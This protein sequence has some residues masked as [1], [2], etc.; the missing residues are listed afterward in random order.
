MTPPAPPARSSSTVPHRGL[1]CQVAE[2][3]AAQKYHHH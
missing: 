1:S 2:D 3:R